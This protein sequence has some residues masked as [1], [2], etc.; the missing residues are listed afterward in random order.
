MTQIPD[1]MQAV[2]CH[3]P[4]DYRLAEVPVP[5][6]G[7]G[8]ALVR[9]EAVGICAS[10]LKCYHGATKFWGDEQRQAYVE[11]PV[12]PGHEFVGR[13]VALDEAAAQRLG[14]AAAVR[15]V[16]RQPPVAPQ[17]DPLPCALWGEKEADRAGP[18]GIRG[19]EAAAQDQPAL[20]DPARMPPFRVVLGDRKI[21]REAGHIQRAPRKELAAHDRQQRQQD[22]GQDQ[23]H[24]TR[25]APHF[26]F[27]RISLSAH[28]RVSGRYRGKAR[29]RAA[30]A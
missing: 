20:V 11:T 1:T 29:R 6:P 2:V 8:E 30:R 9:V 27:L 19:L 25:A 28:R 7:P 5:V 26:R 24:A 22:A 13:V 14:V 16:Q 12:T 4:E 17:I 15:Q 10:D 18:V 21:V 23:R 3:G